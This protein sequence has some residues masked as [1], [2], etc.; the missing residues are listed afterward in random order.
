MCK[1]KQVF[2]YLVS[3]GKDTVNTCWVL[4]KITIPVIIIT[5]ICEELGLIL[6]LSNILEPIMNLTGLPGAYGLIWATAMLTNLYGAVVVFAALVPELQPTAAEATIVCSMMLIAH[7]L[8]VELSISKK[9]GAP[10]IPIALLRIF[11][12]LFYGMILNGICK[13]FG[14]WQ[15]EA[16][17]IFK[18]EKQIQTLLQWS[19]SQLQ[20]LGVIVV[21]IFCILVI[22]RILRL[23]GVLQFLEKMLEP[24][25]PPF[26]MS[27]GAAPITVVG[28]VLGISY[29]GALIIKETTSGKLG[30]K[31]VFFSMALMGL[32]HSLIEDTLLMVAL[33][34][35]LSGILL[36]RLVFSLLV[37]FLL[38]RI[39]ER[40]KASNGLK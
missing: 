16:I 31:D 40:R 20:N 14:V 19:V 6:Y 1:R 39:F 33:G 29:G 9:A 3:L 12:A 11:G 21:V 35:R 36:G 13:T 8:P 18:A 23:L 24:L 38:A 7:S 10:F 37:V 30:R 25:L 34:G 26:G 17:V 15:D 2:K 22:M 27:H 32:S 4:F 5:K 28:M